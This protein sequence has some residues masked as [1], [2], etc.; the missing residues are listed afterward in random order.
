[1]PPSCVPGTARQ[2]R[3]RVKPLMSE[4]A[5]PRQAQIAAHCN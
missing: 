2:I 4:Q 3:Q 1:L 5:Q